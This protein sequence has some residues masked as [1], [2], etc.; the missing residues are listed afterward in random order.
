MQGGRIGVMPIFLTIR[1][2]LTRCLRPRL[3]NYPR[4]AVDLAQAEPDCRKRSKSNRY[5]QTPEVSGL[6]FQ[7]RRNIARSMLRYMR[8]Q[9]LGD[10]LDIGWET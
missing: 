3:R 5:C 6:D 10:F 7:R 8:I 9:M 2:A 4:V 1:R